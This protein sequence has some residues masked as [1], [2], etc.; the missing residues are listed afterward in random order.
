MRGFFVHGITKLNKTMK[1]K[2]I[3]GMI[4]FLLVGGLFA[5][6]AVRE[7]KILKDPVV[8]SSFVL[9][10]GGIGFIC[11]FALISRKEHPNKQSSP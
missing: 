6:M 8:A 5:Y 4:G 7:G 11:G 10:A 2:I 3:Y 9:A 1:K